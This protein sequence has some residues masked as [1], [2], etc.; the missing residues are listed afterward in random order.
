MELKVGDKVKILDWDDWKHH[1]GVTYSMKSWAGRR[2]V[3][4][5]LSSKSWDGK[6]VHN[7]NIDK[8]KTVDWVYT[9]FIRDNNVTD[10][11]ISVLKGKEG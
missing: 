10:V 11:V 7:I 8:Y 2:A 3:I 4:D 5:S 1:K 9:D 6:T